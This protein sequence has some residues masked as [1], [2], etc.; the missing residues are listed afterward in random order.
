VLTDAASLS[1]GRNAHPGYTS[2][3]GPSA[4]PVAA[5]LRLN[6]WNAATSANGIRR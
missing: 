4:A 3:R 5:V 2:M 6:G 1:A